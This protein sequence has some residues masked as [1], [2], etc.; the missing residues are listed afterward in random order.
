MSSVPI[1]SAC[2][3]IPRL[4]ANP[5][6]YCNLRPVN[7]IG[8]RR[9]RKDGAVGV[10][11]QTAEGYAEHLDENLTTL[12]N[13]LKSGSYYAPPVRPGIPKWQSKGRPIGCAHGQG[14]LHCSSTS[15]RTALRSPIRFIRFA[16]NDIPSSPQRSGSS[17]TS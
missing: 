1:G 11:G 14:Q 7:D 17:A 15:F 12:L 9:T 5:L 13:R 8:L 6:R 16:D 10:D 2:F 3:G 4:L